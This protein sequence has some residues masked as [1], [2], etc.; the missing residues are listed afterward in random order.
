M[1]CH[2]LLQ[3]IFLT[4]GS[5]LCLLHWQADCLLLSHQGS[6]EGCVIRTS[7]QQR[8][9]SSV[10]I[11]SLFVCSF[12]GAT[13]A[14]VTTKGRKHRIDTNLCWGKSDLLTVFFSELSKV[15]HRSILSMNSILPGHSFRISEAVGHF[16]ERDK[17]AQRLLLRP[18]E[19]DPTCPPGS[20]PDAS[21][22]LFLFTSHA[23]SLPVLPCRDV[24]VGRGVVLPDTVAAE[25]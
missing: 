3:G 4:Q 20:E 7:R 23:P 22:A 2:F 12:L 13:K 8:A 16:R 15:C 6:T 10:N 18:A 14:D 1:G 25:V 5:N 19:A 11:C 17:E 9:G 24:C 21:P